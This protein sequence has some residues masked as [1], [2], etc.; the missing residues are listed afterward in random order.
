MAFK[1]L[2]N[3]PRSKCGAA[4]DHFSTF[5]FGVTLRALFFTTISVTF[6][7]NLPKKK[8][9]GL[10]GHEL[11]SDIHRREPKFLNNLPQKLKTGTIMANP[12][13]G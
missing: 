6:F 13:D 9:C 3:I 4:I 8:N 12:M 5:P 7:C 10:T 1:I 2:E 11:Y